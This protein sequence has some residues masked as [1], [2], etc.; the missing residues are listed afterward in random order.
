MRHIVSQLPNFYPKLMLTRLGTHDLVC[1]ECDQS[2]YIN[3]KYHLSLL[4]EDERGDILPVYCYD[5]D[6]LFLFDGLSAQQARSEKGIHKLK[7]KLGG[8][9]GDLIDAEYPEDV[10]IPEVYYD[11]LIMSY[12]SATDNDQI[13]YRVFSTKIL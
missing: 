1:K 10:T 12:K 11:F 6:A 9:F 13:A 7:K 4:L 8:I 3:H 5:E 2:A